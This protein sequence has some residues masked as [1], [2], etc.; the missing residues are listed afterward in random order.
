MEN[1]T[2][3]QQI[4]KVEQWLA[5]ALKPYQ[6]IQDDRSRRYYDCQDDTLIGGIS[7]QVTNEKMRQ[8]RDSAELAIEEIKQAY[9]GKSTPV[10]I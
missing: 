2:K 5:A 9:F 8:L 4:N 3:E 7:W 10:W 1:L 6:E